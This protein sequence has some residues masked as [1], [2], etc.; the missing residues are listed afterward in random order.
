MPKSLVVVSY[1][2]ERPANELIRLL[3]QIRQTEAGAPFDTAIVVNNASGE[4]LVLPGHFGDLR[5]FHRENTGFNIGAWQYAWR[6]APDYDFYLFLQDDCVIERAGW[7]AA[8]L[9]ASNKPKS[10]F[11]GESM[12]HHPSWQSYQ[13][14]Y[15]L[16]FESCTTLAEQY[17]V[18]L[19]VRPDHLQTLIMGAAKDVLVKTGGF[20]ADDDK[21]KAIAGEVLTSRRAAQMGYVN[22]QIAA[23]PFE[24]ISHPQWAGLRANSRTLRW[25]VSQA[26]YRWAPPWLLRWLRR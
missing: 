16:N 2:D 11:V 20:I 5:I 10:G 18:T 13:R 17:G 26:G 15:P 1:Y 12:I 23:R 7:L 8:H 22:R 19:G 6:N 14:T 25:R 3:H 4:P 9:T 24:F 21:V